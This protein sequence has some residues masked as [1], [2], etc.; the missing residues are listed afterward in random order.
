MEALSAS[1][2]CAL[3][4]DGRAAGGLGP[5]VGLSLFLSAARRGAMQ[6]FADVAGRLGNACVSVGSARFGAALTVGLKR[7]GRC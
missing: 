4:D 1:G 2:A 3:V 7:G 5:R 6:P